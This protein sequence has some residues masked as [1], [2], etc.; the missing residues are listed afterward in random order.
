MRERERRRQTGDTRTKWEKNADGL[1]GIHEGER[2]S[3]RKETNPNQNKWLRQA[4][5]ILVGSLQEDCKKLS[6]GFQHACASLRTFSNSIMQARKL[7]QDFLDCKLAQ[8]YIHT[9]GLK[10]C[11]PVVR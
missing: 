3:E 2:D 11:M 9:N 7:A 1:H 10:K 4:C 6:I 5:C 8:V